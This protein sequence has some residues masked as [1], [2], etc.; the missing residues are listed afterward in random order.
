MAMKSHRS[1]PPAALVIKWPLSVHAETARDMVR[2]LSASRIPATWAVNRGPQLEALESWGAVRDGADAAL[3]ISANG[4]AA[5]SDDP[6]GSGCGDV[7]RQLQALRGFPLRVDAVL[8]SAGLTSGQ[9]PRTWRALG[10]RGFVIDE[11]DDA[12]AARALP[13]GIWQFTPRATVPR[14][15]RWT[16]WLRRRRPVFNSRTRMPLLVAVDLARSGTAG[17]RAWRETEAVLEQ[18]VAA[19]REGAV[20]LATLGELIDEFAQASAPRPQR[21]ILRAA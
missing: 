13:F 12:G 1:V 19:R 11:G 21:S 20:R 10:V 17:S 4:G 8:G 3:A 6:D 18:A 15:P 2:R 5:P 7:A 16:N 14:Q 9:W